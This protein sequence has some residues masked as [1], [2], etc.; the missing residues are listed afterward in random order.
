[1]RLGRAA[2][3]MK[4]HKYGFFLELYMQEEHYNEP[5]HS[6]NVVDNIFKIQKNDESIN[7]NNNINIAWN[8]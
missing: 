3:K 2:Q 7:A 4:K 6:L 1:M 8:R 5:D